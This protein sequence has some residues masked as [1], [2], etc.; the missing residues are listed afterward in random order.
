MMLG[1]GMVGTKGFLKHQA[2]STLVSVHVPT[3]ASEPH[4][5]EESQASDDENEAGETGTTHEDSV[6]HAI[7]EQ[8]VSTSTSK[9]TP[10]TA[11]SASSTKARKT[12]EKRKPQPRWET[13]SF[14]GKIPR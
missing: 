1:M 7:Q 6:A 4:T 11:A 5:V 8:Q 13:Y 3:K 14:K 12:E 10:V 2:L 9:T